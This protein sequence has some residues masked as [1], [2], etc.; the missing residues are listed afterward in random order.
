MYHP[1]ENNES[2]YHT[3]ERQT[4]AEGS[5]DS[6]ACHSTVPDCFSAESELSLHIQDMEMQTDTNV[7]RKGCW[8]PIEST[9]TCSQMAMIEWESGRVDQI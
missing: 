7:T 3:K 8:T 2:R 1:K 9:V 6:C 4:N 5:D